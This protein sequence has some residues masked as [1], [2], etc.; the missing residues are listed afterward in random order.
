MIMRIVCIVERSL[1]PDGQHQ[2]LQEV[3]SLHSRCNRQVPESLSHPAPA[4]HVRT[5]SPGKLNIIL[6]LS[7]SLAD[8]AWHALRDRGEDQAVILTG[9]SGAGKTEAGKLVMQYI[10][11]VTGHNRHNQDIKYQL[12]QANPVLEGR[13]CQRF[14]GSICW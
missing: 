13:G 2:S 14:D 1:Q 11:A 7:Y 3:V 4:S 8:R 12:L 9:E 5:L 6:L 10:A